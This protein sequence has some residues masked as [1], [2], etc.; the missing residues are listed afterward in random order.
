MTQGLFIDVFGAINMQWTWISLL[1][2]FMAGFLVAVLFARFGAG[3]S[4]LEAFFRGLSVLY[5]SPPRI[6]RALSVWWENRQRSRLQEVAAAKEIEGLEGEID[7][8]K[9]QIVERRRKIGEAR[10]QA[11]KP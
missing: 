2:G 5:R 10:W 1:I 4:F 9:E 3:R 6:S 7:D 8:L 11:K